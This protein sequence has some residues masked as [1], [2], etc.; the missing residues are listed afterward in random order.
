MTRVRDVLV[1]ELLGGFG[2]LLLVLPAVHALAAAHPAARLRV[3]TF[4]PG[5]DLLAADPT[6]AEVIAVSDRGEGAA[7]RAVA[8]ELARRTPDVVVSTTSYGGIPKLLQA[9]GARQVVSNLWRRPPASERVDRRFLRLLAADGLVPPAEVDR[10]LHVVLTA[11]ERAAGRHVLAEVAPDAIPPVVLV[12]GTG[13]AVKAWPPAAWAALVAAMAPRPVL[14]TAEP[15]GSR[16]DLAVRRLPPGGLRGLAAIFS[17][18]AERGGVV[19]GGDT[20]PVRLATAAGARAVG[21]YGPTVASRYGL[22]PRRSS[23]LQGL[24]ECDVRLPTSITEQEC[25]WS[26]HCPLTSAEPACMADIA[27]DTVV[28][29]VHSELALAAGEAQRAAS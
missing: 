11:P 19:V 10:P 27:V 12:P 29:A 4:P 18:V 1:V 23:S 22:D 14:A 26:G 5:A 6:V 16:S 25:W 9:S 2:D 7:A 8:A 28:A 13:M 17:A 3:L 21:L 24:L 20:G 15:S